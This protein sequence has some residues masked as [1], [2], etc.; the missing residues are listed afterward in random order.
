L[1][2]LFWVLPHLEMKLI[3]TSK[4]LPLRLRSTVKV[5]AISHLERGRHQPLTHTNK[6]WIFFVEMVNGANWII[7][8]TLLRWID[9]QTDKYEIGNMKWWTSR[10]FSEF[11]GHLCN[12]YTVPFLMRTILPLNLPVSAKIF[13][14]NFQNL[15]RVKLACAHY[16]C[17]DWQSSCF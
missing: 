13:R 10:R 9:R 5:K 17:Y 6:E 3:P 4:S 14:I 1:E 16:V 11:L 2:N 15:D 7:Y 8:Q 12:K